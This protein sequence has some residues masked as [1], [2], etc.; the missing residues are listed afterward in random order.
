VL[1]HSCRTQVTK[2]PKMEKKDADIIAEGDEEEEE[3]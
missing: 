1:N 3:D 2:A